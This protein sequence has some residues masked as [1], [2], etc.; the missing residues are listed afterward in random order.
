[1]DARASNLCANANDTA[2]GQYETKQNSHHHPHAAP[3]TSAHPSRDVRARPP[4]SS[5]RLTSMDKRPPAPP[6]TTTTMDDAGR[7]RRDDGA[8]TAPR[9]EGGHAR[10][11]SRSHASM[12][13]P[14]ASWRWLTSY[15]RALASTTGGVARPTPRSSPAQQPSRRAGHRGDRATPA[16][17]ISR[18]MDIDAPIIAPF[19]GGCTCKYV[20]GCVHIQGC[21]CLVYIWLNPSRSPTPRAKGAPLFF[22]VRCPARARG[23]VGARA[24][25]PGARHGGGD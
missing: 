6:W 22:F 17:E 8:T 23:W 5:P 14:R 12:H 25:G 3:A 4:P 20:C 18:T 10:E 13:L 9:R 7:R 24:D 16:R 19:G 2:R 15:A 21:T 11:S 1:V